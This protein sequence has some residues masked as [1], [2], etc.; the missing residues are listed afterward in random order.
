MAQNTQD[1]EVLSDLLLFWEEEHEK[2]NSIAPEELCKEYPHLLEKVTQGVNALK[3]PVWIEKAPFTSE[4]IS[5]FLE[6]LTLQSIIKDRFRIDSILGTGGHGIVY[7]AWDLQLHRFVAIK[8]AKNLRKIPLNEKLELLEEA[9][10]ISNLKHPGILP[11]YDI[12]E[13]NDTYLLVS[14]FVEEGDL[15]STIKTKNLNLS[16]KITLLCK[17]AIALGHAHENGIVHRDL[18]PN[19]ILLTDD[20][21]P[22]I[23]DFGNAFD[24]GTKETEFNIGSIHYAAPEQLQGNQPDFSSDIWSFGAILHQLVTGKLP[25]NANSPEE[26][27]Q[28]IAHQP[29][30]PIRI[31]IPAVPKKLDDIFLIC[32]QKDPAK[33]YRSA[34][35]L[36]TDLQSLLASLNSK[37][38]VKK[39]IPIA[40]GTLGIVLVGVTT[41]W[42][43]FMPITRKGM[44]IVRAKSA[45]PLN[46]E[47]LAKLNSQLNRIEFWANPKKKCWSQPREGLFLGDGVGNLSF[48][49]PL[50]A[51][52]TLYFDLKVMDG[53]RARL[54]LNNNTDD[55]SERK[56]L[57]I[58]NE[59]F[60]RTIGVYG[61]GKRASFEKQLPYEINQL[62]HCKLTLKDSSYLFLVDGEEVSKGTFNTSEKHS[63]ILHL[64]SGD[65]YSPGT[66]EFSNMRLDP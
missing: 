59:G 6:F 31:T 44:E 56:L 39:N 41:Y 17:I 58:G 36:A 29:A 7:K 60:T 4:P 55:K 14:E 66:V 40:L 20:L 34:A 23:C 10:K 30:S 3:A 16:Q 37:K 47:N 12:L 63:L 13:F 28:Q 11:L 27:I 22:K 32:M 38:N 9:R 5:E 35:P 26:L 53:L 51:N 33:R 46:P 1:E 24:K 21:E 8:S 25:F 52:F 2:G 48:K 54:I 42:Y 62:L 19:N 50:P 43:T 49:E 15:A 61:P 18:K 64:S 45:L 65:N 57:H